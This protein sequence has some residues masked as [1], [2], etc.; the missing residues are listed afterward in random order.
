MDR[1]EAMQLLRDYVKN[2]ALIRHML[3]VEAA[4]GHYARRSGHDDD[5]WRITGLLHDFD[6][7]RWPEPPQHTREGA[8]ILREKGV[9]EEI[10]T[11]ILSHADWNSEDCPRDTPL[12]KTLFAVDELCGFIY[13][14]ALVRPDRLQGMKVKSITKKMKQKSFAAAVSRDD[15]TQG[16]ALIGMPLN[17]HIEQCIQAMSAISDDLGLVVQNTPNHPNVDGS[18]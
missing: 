11:A 5:V 4:M 2:E 15:I 17:D 14:A 3:A 18:H 8:K 10:V 13:A 7:E 1:C 6:Y 16:A 9:D 12:R